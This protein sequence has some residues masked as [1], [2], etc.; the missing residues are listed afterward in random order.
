MNLEYYKKIDFDLEVAEKV[1]A[2]EYYRFG[3]CFTWCETEEDEDYW[4]KFNFWLTSST[5]NK[6]SLNNRPEWRRFLEMVEEYKKLKK[7]PVEVTVASTS[8]VEELQRLATRV[9]ELEKSLGNQTWEKFEFS[10]T[11]FEPKKSTDFHIGDTVWRKRANKPPVECC[12]RDIGEKF[13]VVTSHFCERIDPSE[14]FVVEKSK[15][16]KYET[17]QKS[18]APCYG[19][20]GSEAKFAC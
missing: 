6:H 1:L 16:W 12:V 19:A 11:W 7:C 10:G 5:S 20:G 3:D 2:G 8:I 13:L 17:V 15:C 9:E 14:Y 4:F 18:P